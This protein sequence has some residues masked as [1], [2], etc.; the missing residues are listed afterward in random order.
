ERVRITAQ[1]NEVATGKQLWAER[2]D[3]QLSDVFAI[4]DEITEAVVAAI[5]PHVYANESFR[6][7]RKAPESLD[8]W[9]L[10]MRGLPHYWRVTREDHQ[11]ARQLLERAIAADP[12]YAQALAVFAV[13]IM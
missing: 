2:Y 1:L 11:L 6:A 5:E 7:Q 4:Q 9:D 12:N 10:V 8:A 13:T 3:R